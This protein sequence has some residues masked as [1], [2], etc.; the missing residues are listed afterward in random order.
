MY[1]TPSSIRTGGSGQK[2]CIPRAGVDFAIVV[3]DV[4]FYDL[5]LT[6]VPGGHPALKNF[7]FTDWQFADD[8][9][10]VVLFL[11]IMGATSILATLVNIGISRYIKHHTGREAYDP[12]TLRFMVHVVVA[13][14]YI[15]GFCLAVYTIPSLRHVATTLLTGAGILTAVIG[16][17]SQQ[18]LSNVI[19][20]IFIIISKPYRINNNIS[21]G[22]NIEGVVED[23][24]LRNTVIRDY[25]NR[26]IIIPNAMISS[27]AVVNTD[28]TDRVVC[29]W[30][31]VGIAYHA[32]VKQ[33]K[34]IMREEVT[35][36][37]LFIDHRTKKQ[38]K[39]EEEA[40]AV[41]VISLG[42]FSV[43]LRAWAWAA[44][45]ANGLVLQY[46]VLETIKERFDAE[47]IEIP[48]PY[49][50]TVLQNVPNQPLIDD[51]WPTEDGPKKQGNDE[52]SVN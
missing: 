32:N 23:I 1:Y 26:R 20:G 2:F 7:I 13:I 34:S 48:Y 24:D 11:G 44:N 33:A 31:E 28:H 19:S 21:L 47:G 15:V 9:K 8:T 29:R 22:D 25:Q 43:T 37:P 51:V 36:H 46:D 50:N 5:W 12:T 42:D 6:K 18:V 16:F 35:K 3:V 30:I 10:Y 52:G 39:A 40:V 41:R 45:Y 38:L 49:Q 14:I 27:Q 4:L 17:A